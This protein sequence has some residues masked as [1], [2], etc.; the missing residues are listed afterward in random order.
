[1]KTPKN[2]I[3]QLSADTK[4]LYRLLREVKVG[5]L[6]TFAAISKTIGL[7]V[8]GSF[9]AL[10]SARRKALNHDGIVFGAVVG[11]G[12]RRLT[13]VEIVDSVASDRRYIRNRA[14]RSATKLLTVEYSKLSKRSKAEY[15]AALSIF[16]AMFRLTDERNVLKVEGYVGDQELP[17]VETVAAIEGTV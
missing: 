12:I 9:P 16:G 10:Q 5:Q 14:R 4:T 17:L 1:M 13:D 3:F 8:D 15:I 11:V 2:M 7:R 6:L